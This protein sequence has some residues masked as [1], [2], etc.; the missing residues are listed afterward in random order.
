MAYA[1]GVADEPLRV[2]APVVRIVDHGAST[3]VLGAELVR[4]FDGDSASLLRAV[5]E[6]HARP[7]GRTQLIAELAA[8]SGTTPEELPAPPIEELIGLLVGDGVLVAAPTTPTVP[9]MA[10]GGLRRVVLSVSG[11]VA[12]VD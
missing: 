10:A 11:A 3:T 4:R 9:T 2:R 6:I 1:R 12:A 5:L 8:R 7:V